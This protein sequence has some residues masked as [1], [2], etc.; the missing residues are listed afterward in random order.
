MVDELQ[1]LSQAFQAADAIAQEMGKRLHAL[2]GWTEDQIEA[3]VRAE[4]RK[5]AADDP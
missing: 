5:D 1:G 3:L 4:L 2:A